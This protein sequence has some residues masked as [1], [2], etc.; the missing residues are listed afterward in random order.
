MEDE[1]ESSR[2]YFNPLFNRSFDEIND[3]DKKEKSESDVQIIEADDDVEFA[4]KTG[5]NLSFRTQKILDKT[6]SSNN[7]F[8]LK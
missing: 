6:I 4:R 3:G 5:F 7:I 8:Y 1:D 2:R